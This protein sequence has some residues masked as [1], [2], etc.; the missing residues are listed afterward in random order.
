MAIRRKQDRYGRKS[1]RVFLVTTTVIMAVFFLVMLQSLFAPSA[2]DASDALGQTDSRIDS[3]KYETIAKTAQDIKRGD[4]IL[5]N[6]DHSFDFAD[7][8]EKPTVYS[9]KN[10]CYKAKDKFIKLNAHVSDAFNHFMEDFYARSRKDYVTVVS[11]YR[12]YQYQKSLYENKIRK[13][14]QQEADRYIQK[15]GTSEHH[16]G[17]ALDLGIT[18]S[19]GTYYEFEGVG[20]YQWIG[21]NAHRYGFIVRYAQEK[22]SI[23]KI[24]HEPWHLRYV[25]KPHAYWMKEKNMCL[26][27]YIDYLKQFEFSRK[28]LTIEDDE[29]QKYQIYYVPSDGGRTNVPVPKDSQYTVSGN[30][31]DGFIVTV[32][33]GS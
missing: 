15:P 11:A 6:A 25:G 24:Y 33:L 31:V 2:P 9:Q 20:E 1:N 18:D 22:A 19:H 12:T 29:H 13:D 26:E 7:E 5:V 10:Q 21:Q 14:G 8:T 23:T 4:L 16:T 32:S 27:E 17:N 28:H 30:N 3:Q